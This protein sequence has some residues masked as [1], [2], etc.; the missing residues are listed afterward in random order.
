MDIAMDETVETKISTNLTW[1]K[2][3]RNGSRRERLGRVK[4]NKQ[5]IAFV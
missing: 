5:K 3:N 1:E 2:E 4:T